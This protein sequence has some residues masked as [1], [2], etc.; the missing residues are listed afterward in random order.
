M[1][2]YSL[3]PVSAIGATGCRFAGGC[4]LPTNKTS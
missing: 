2:E 3:N 1:I 4:Q